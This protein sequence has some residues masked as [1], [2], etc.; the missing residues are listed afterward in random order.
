MRAQKVL[1]QSWNIKVQHG[2]H[3]LLIGCLH[4]NYSYFIL[5]KIHF[6]AYFHSTGNVGNPSICHP[7][8][9]QLPQCPSSIT[10]CLCEMWKRWLPG[11][12]VSTVL[13][14]CDCQHRLPRP[15]FLTL[16]IYS[17]GETTGSSRKSSGSRCLEQMSHYFCS[18]PVISFFTCF[19]YFAP[20]TPVYLHANILPDN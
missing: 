7:S 13:P 4:F 5:H 10:L 2:K 20:L 12:P 17:Q 3:I 1:K 11:D 8:V 14:L 19:Q 16:L 15:Y 9:L 6:R 18:S